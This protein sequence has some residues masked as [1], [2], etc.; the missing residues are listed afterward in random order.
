MV[1]VVNFVV[2]C[3][4]VIAMSDLVH[5]VEGKHGLCLLLTASGKLFLH[6]SDALESANANG[7]FTGITHISEKFP[8]CC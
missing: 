6:M 1:L 3:C 2:I 7:S 8:R 4:F 5:D